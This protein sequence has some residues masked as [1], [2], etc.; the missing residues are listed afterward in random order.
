M[1]IYNK[2]KNNRDY[3]WYDSSNVL[4]SECYDNNDTK[5]II[6]VVFKQGRTYLY[7][8]VDVNDYICFKNS[9]SNGKAINEYIIKK[10]KGIRLSDT[11]LDV[12]SKEKDDFIN[13]DKITD[14][15]FTNLSYHMDMNNETGEF[16]LSLNDKCIFEGV[17]NNVSILRL[18]KSMNIRYSFNTDWDGHISNEQEYLDEQKPK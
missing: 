15:A 5:K 13:E 2:Y 3:T 18:L 8:D 11:D 12:I 10:Y 16:R 1:I 9:D 7:R 4:Y 14:E 17:E 6:K